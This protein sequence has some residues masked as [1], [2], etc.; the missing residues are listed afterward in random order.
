MYVV[1][2]MWQT[3]SKQNYDFTTSI[4]QSFIYYIRTYFLC[5]LRQQ[6]SIKKYAKTVKNRLSW[7]RHYY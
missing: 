6:N 2:R 1:R 4:Y 5:S 7:Y 3:L